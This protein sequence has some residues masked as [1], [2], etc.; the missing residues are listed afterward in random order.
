MGKQSFRHSSI[1]GIEQASALADDCCRSKLGHRLSANTGRLLNPEQ[2]S[3]WKRHNP[4]S[5]VK[6]GPL[7]SLQECSGIP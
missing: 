4:Q 3:A 7:P 2:T 6:N 1:G 5:D